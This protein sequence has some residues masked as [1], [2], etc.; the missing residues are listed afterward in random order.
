MS[1]EVRAPLFDRLV[2]RDPRWRRE[3][4]PLRT[5]D[6]EGLLESVRREL[7]RLLNTRAP[8]PPEELAGRQRTVID[9]GV[10]D[11]ANYSPASHDDRRRLAEALRQAIAAYEPRLAQVKVTVEPAPAEEGALVGRIDAVLVVEEVHEP[12]SFPTIFQGATGE[13]EVHAGQ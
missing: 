11:F 4:R 12:V 10:P 5:L 6:R 13:V 3:L 7:A 9:Y 2:D 1:S 8:L